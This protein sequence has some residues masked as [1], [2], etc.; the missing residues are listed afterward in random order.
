[1]LR[2]GSG[3]SKVT[4]LLSGRV[5]HPACGLYRSPQRSLREGW[6]TVPP[7]TA[8]DVGLLCTPSLVLIVLKQRRGLKVA[9][10]PFS[11]FLQAS[12]PSTGRNSS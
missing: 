10:E 1:M 9:S 7:L 6:V 4:Q 5:R 2:E 3:L 12:P 8:G 11:P